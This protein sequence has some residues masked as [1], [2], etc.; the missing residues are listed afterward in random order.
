MP[1]ALS[2]RPYDTDRLVDVAVRVFN[3]RGYDAT[4]LDDLAKATRLAKS[5]IYHHVGSKEELLRR[6][7]ERALDELFAMLDE[8]DVAGRRGADRLRVV[9]RR[10]VEITIE[11]RSEVALLLRVRGNSRTEQWAMDRRRAFDRRVAA[12][13]AEAVRAGELRDDL[14]PL[15]TTRLIFGMMNSITEWYRPGGKLGPAEIASIVER[16]L[17]QGIWSR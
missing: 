15:V 5:S 9:V 8:P 13:V 1:A 3:R 14:E 10:T 6:G 7:V 16:M 2:R 11:H 12:M 4:S 17:F